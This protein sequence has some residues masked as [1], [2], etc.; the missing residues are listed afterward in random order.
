MYLQMVSSIFFVLLHFLLLIYPMFLRSYL[1]FSYV[2]NNHILNALSLP[3]KN[4]IINR[5]DPSLI[6]SS[7]L[8]ISFIAI[9]ILEFSIA[10]YSI[11]LITLIH[12][13]RSV[14]SYYC[15]NVFRV[16]IIRKKLISQNILLHAESKNQTQL[17]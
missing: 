12:I 11:F 9:F 5:I 13:A 17:S 14:K 4:Q 2:A 1:F 8:N 10:F 6:R 3:D 15:L 7:F 16:K